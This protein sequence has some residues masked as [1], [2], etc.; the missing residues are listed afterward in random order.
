MRDFEGALFWLKDSMVVNPCYKASEPALGLSLNLD[1]SALKCYMADTGLLVSHSFS[2]N[3][4]AADD[5]HR[6]LLFERL[7]FNEGMIVENVVAQ[8]IVASGRPLFFFSNYSKSSSD[9]CM[10]ID[11]LLAKSKIGSHRNLFP[12][13]VKSGKNYTLKSLEKFCRKYSRQLATPY[14]L[15]TGEWREQNGVVF[16]PFYLAPLL[17]SPEWDHQAPCPT[18]KSP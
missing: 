13:E 18:S 2:E 4:L 9:D 14:L 3:K 1:A 12:I 8:I 6:R 15:H 17:C 7:E 5:I 16:L 10:E 11:F